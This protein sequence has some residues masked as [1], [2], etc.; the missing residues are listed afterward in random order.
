MD[1]AQQ[2][3]YTIEFYA[4]VQALREFFASHPRR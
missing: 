3:Q 4:T 2:R 1:T